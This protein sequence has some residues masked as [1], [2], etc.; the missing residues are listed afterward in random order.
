MSAT[1]VVVNITIVVAVACCAAASA[2][3]A[4][5]DPAALEAPSAAVVPSAVAPAA[6]DLRLDDPAARSVAQPREPR[7]NP[8]WA[9]PVPTLSATRERPL[10]LPSRHPPVAPAVA[11]TVVVAAQPVEDPR[12]RLALLGAVAG[13]NDEIA[14]FLDLRSNDTI[15]LRTGQE[16][17]GWTLRSVKGRQAVLAKDK[18][19]AV[20]VLPAPGTNGTASIASVPTD[21]M[22]PV[23]TDLSAPAGKAATATTPDVHGVKLAPGR[24]L[25]A[26]KNAGVFAPFTPHSTPKNRES[27]GL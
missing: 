24:P 15:R 25:V 3:I 1:R 10:F 22:A 5:N 11:G 6:I 17:G 7:G 27:D 21:L 23:P 16:H 20:F 18:E 12:P 13:E 14:I 26:P 19:T 4:P 8:L 2:V 9:I